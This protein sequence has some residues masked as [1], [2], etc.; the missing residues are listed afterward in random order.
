MSNAA[1]AQFLDGLRAARL[2]DDSRI[3][4]LRA[5]PEANWDDVHSLG[6][7]AEGQGWLSA[8]QVAEV[9][10]GR[11]DGLTIAN[12]RVV[13]RL[14]DGPGGPTYKALHPSLTQPVT[15]Q[16]LRT[17]W[18]G[19]ADNPTSY[20]ARARAASLVQSPH[21]TNVL[22]AG[23]IADASFVVQESV[24]G[25]D[26]FHLVNEMGALPYGLACEYTRQAAVAL[27]AAHAKGVSHGAVSPLSVLL[28]P[29]K[30]AV[31]TNGDV[32]YRPR[33]GATVK[34]VD[35]AVAPVRPPMGEVPIKDTD[36][37]GP[38][39]YLPPEQFTRTDR[40]PAGDVYGLG[41]TLYYLLTG[42]PPYAGATAHEA[43][44]NLHQS[45]PRRVDSLRTDLPPAV[46]EL[47]HKLLD[48][49]PY[50]RPSAEDAIRA[51][52]PYCEPSARPGAIDPEV[53]PEVP[54]AAE[55]FTQS[56]APEALPVATR[57]D[58]PVAE[59][60]FADVVPEAPPLPEPAVADVAHPAPGIEV[61]DD[62][63]EHGHDGH[64]DVFGPGGYTSQPRAP[65]PKV[66]APYTAKQKG[67]LVLGLVLHLTATCMC[68]GLM[69]IIPNPF[70]APPPEKP[71]KKEEPPKKTKQPPIRS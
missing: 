55:T 60:A 3:D 42:R 4:E 28:T 62:H 67:M 22:D 35:L 18:L 24:E 40:S 20:V 37:L 34:V 57:L 44:L 53:A 30:K 47:V 51:L 54:G 52:D 13:D 68:L 8:Y 36:R 50:A 27:A 69:G 21:L 61:L 59:P 48:R 64:S 17:D 2:L 39:A 9:R 12:Y 43:M 7:Y 10:E 31:G 32:S 11:G 26:L 29:V 66:R 46:S 5:R 71:Q 16:L 70:A 15:L 56:A 33:P 49:N 41:A 6:Q 25:C 23:T 1:T 58:E 45:E 14:R 65:K 38:V 63:H 19:P